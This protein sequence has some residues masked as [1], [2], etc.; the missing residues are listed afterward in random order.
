MGG[1]YGTTARFH[2]ESGLLMLGSYRDINI[3]QTLKVFEGVPRWLRSRAMMGEELRRGII[4][5]IGGL[6]TPQ[7]PH[8]WAL[9]HFQDVLRGV[10]PGYRQQER[11]EIFETSA[12]HTRHL[13][14]ILEQAAAA[15][16]PVVVLGSRAALSAAAAARA[17]PWLEISSLE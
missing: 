9:E 10:P 5:A 14:E 17:T 1:A 13:A 8:D 4:G 15:R 6:D 11:D 7:S 2:Q 16:A 12:S 3:V